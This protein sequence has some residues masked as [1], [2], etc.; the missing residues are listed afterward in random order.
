MALI[1]VVDHSTL[2]Q[3]I[4]SNALTDRGHTVLMA[5]N[6]RT[7]LEMAIKQAPEIIILNLEMPDMDKFRLLEVI[8]EE[9]PGI[10]TIGLSV[11]IQESSRRRWENLGISGFINKPIRREELY[12]VTDHLMEKIQPVASL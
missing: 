4:I 8:R 12:E 3:A 7:G 1:L 6:G 5:G 2:I 10:A 9:R 11:D